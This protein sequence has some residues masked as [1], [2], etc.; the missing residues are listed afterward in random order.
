[1][2]LQ[3]LPIKTPP[4]RHTKQKQQIAI[5]MAIKAARIIGNSRLAKQT[6]EF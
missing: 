3:R 1:L 4:R 2:F 6:P 5:Q